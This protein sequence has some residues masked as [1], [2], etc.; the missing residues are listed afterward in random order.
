MNEIEQQPD[1]IVEPE[2]AEIPPEPVKKKTRL[3]WIAAAIIGV[4]IL[5]AAAFLGARLLKSPQG[6]FVEG[7]GQMIRTGKG[8]GQG[9]STSSTSVQI[10]PSKELPER[11]SD[12]S[13]MISEI[14]DRSLFVRTGTQ[15]MVMMNEKGEAAADIADEGPT[16]EVVVTDDTQ[17]Y[18]DVTF[19][20]GV[21][22]NGENVTVQQKVE[23]VDFSDIED[24]AMVSI[25]GSKRGDRLIAEVIMYSPPPSLGGK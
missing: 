11:R 13:G 25:W 9:L 14:K 8:S 12:A 21:P 24:Q 7:Q 23:P 6:D 5:G 10:E 4:V 1:P 22:D 15:F 2:V 3:V 16:V 17:I 19:E 20:N 18:K